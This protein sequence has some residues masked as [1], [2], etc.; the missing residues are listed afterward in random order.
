M[1][2]FIKEYANK[3]GVLIVLCTVFSCSNDEDTSELSD[4]IFVRHKKADMPAYIHGN[5]SEKLFLIILHGG[6][7]GIGLNYRSNTIK[8]AIEKEC[9]VVYFDQRGSGMAQGSYSENG[10]NIDIMAEDV[11]ALVKV[12][13]HK[14]GNDSRFFLMGHSWGGALGPATLLKDQ[15]DFLGWIDV[16]GSH[17]P[18]SM[19]LEYIANFKRVAAEQITAGNETQY[20]ES[21]IELTNTVAP[22]YNMEDMRKLNSEAFK[23]EEKLADTNVINENVE[24]DENTI[25]KYNLLTLFWNMANTQSI[26]DEDLF[27]N[28]TFK[29]R[30]KEIK[31]P[32]LILWGKYDMVVPIRYAQDSYD[33]LGASNKKLVIFEKSGHSPMATEPDLFAEEVITFIRDN[34]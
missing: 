30:L 31:V 2:K 11:L 17:N 19:Y 4:T 1:Q 21:L 28:I 7:G 5:A 10:I 24:S 27:Q 22:E 14:Y 15:T 16:D 8:D 20:W 32:S 29:D 13:K 9:V 33:N 3:I 25:L 23:A 12:I 18:K 34:K 26:L 6:P